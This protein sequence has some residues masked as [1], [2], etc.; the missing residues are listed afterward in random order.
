LRKRLLLLTGNPGVG[1]TT[2]LLKIV[3]TVR[4][5]DYRAGGMV[6]REVRSCGARVGF[7]LLDLRSS[8]RG[9]LAHVNQSSGPSV[10]RYRVNIHDL[11]RLGAEAIINAIHNCD[12]V[13]IDEVGP[14]ELLSERFKEA[15]KK[16][17]ESEKL[18]IGI[19]HW[20]ARN[21]LIEEMR[22]R[23]DAETYVVT[24]ENRERLLEIIVSRAIEMLREN[25]TK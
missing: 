9:W 5:N 21:V 25:E 8:K 14:M 13:F 19:V 12:A 7:E 24:S 3:E 1:K 18:V 15:V 10:G 2:L 4:S 11:E 6:S 22:R 16:A 17:V 23:E 20:K